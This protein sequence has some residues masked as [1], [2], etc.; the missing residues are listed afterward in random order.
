MSAPDRG[1]VG[2]LAMFADKQQ[3]VPAWVAHREGS[4]FVLEPLGGERF[5]A[6]GARLFWAGRT[7]LHGPSDLAARWAL[8]RDR[9][10]SINLEALWQA[11]E[12]A[13]K[14]GPCDMDTLV[15]LAR[16]P[17]EDGALVEDALALAIFSDPTYFKLKDRTLLRESAPAVAETKRKRL[18]REYQREQLARAT[19]AFAARLAREA[20]ADDDTPAF[21]AA[22][23]ALLDV[24]A[25][26]REAASWAGIQPLCEALG[27]H[28]DQCFDLLVRAGELEADANLAPHRAKVPLA[29]SPEVLAE[30]SKVA[31][32]RPS[33]SLDLTH[34]EALA[35]D[36]PDTTEVDD[37]VAFD[38]GRVVVLIADAASYVQPGS[39]LD[40]DA[41]LRTATL[42]LPEG[43][44]PMLPPELGEGPMSLN[45]GEAR[46]AL[47]FS[48]EV[49][50]DGRL[51]ALEVARA[52]ARIARRISYEDADRL[53]TTDRDSPLGRLLAPLD[54]AMTRHR[55]HR[56]AQGAVT[57][58]RPEV[59]FAREPDGRVRIK[60]GDPLGP[61]R[62]LI[63]ELM[64]AACTAAAVFCA[65]RQIP[66]I[67][68]AQA[69]PDDPPGRR[70]GPRGTEAAA[71]AIN[72]ASGRVDDA[73]LQHDLLR[74]LK[75]ST[76][77]TTPASHW[78]LAVPAYSQ[79]TS[80]IRRYA[81]L[82][83]HQQLTS[84]LK[85]G[86]PVHSTSRLEGQLEDLQ[87]RQVLVRRVEQESRRFYALRYLA[88]NPG[89]TLTGTV[90]REVGRKTL[91]ELAPIAI[92]ELIT[93]RRR[94]APG[95]RIAF[96]VI[97]VDP[98][99]DEL[100]LKERE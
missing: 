37:A 77:Q 23:N 25:L 14:D 33:P 95:T 97:A 57:F 16:G 85:T 61:G 68:R 56:H 19:R 90:L 20:M 36:D 53:L 93:P 78:T 38:R 69:A 44:V 31:T 26:G 11:L 66:C 7:A 28:P 50:D 94:M 99:K 29:F 88:Q 72:P 27:I 73:A 32:L 9:A 40:K 1:D 3:L 35:I 52:R 80:P 63:A 18:E 21:I 15:R 89:L 24:A 60:V 71:R 42:Y 55:A 2:T 46:S 45:P 83:M 8:T 75:P 39:L 98:R 92:Q 81:D 10:E 100:H 51:V 96:E 64:V 41:A 48:F 12:G 62:Q 58:Q 13:P 79:V 6:V 54:A 43:K 22:R 30:A 5:A 65:E 87:R 67:Y 86:R 74:R 84:V 59:Y 4:R 91:I 34:L 47:A 76:L 70:N 17:S 82:L 49:A